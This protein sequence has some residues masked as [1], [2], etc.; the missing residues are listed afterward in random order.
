MPSVTRQLSVLLGLGVTRSRLRWAPVVRRAYAPAAQYAPPL[1]AALRFAREE[2]LPS[3]LNS[4]G[5]L[6]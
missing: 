5:A 2:L 4:G 6:S 3:Q 1:A